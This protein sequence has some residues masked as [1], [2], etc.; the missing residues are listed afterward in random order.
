MLVLGLYFIFEGE[1]I[2]RYV[3]SRKDFYQYSQALNEFPTI[4]TALLSPPANQSIGKDFNMSLMYTILTDG[5]ND[6]QNPS[7]PSI[8]QV[9]FNYWLAGD[10]IKS[11]IRP[12]TSYTSGGWVQVEYT[13]ANA[14]QWSKTKVVIDLGTG[15]NS[16]CYGYN[17]GEVSNAVAK[18]GELHVLRVQPEKFIYLSDR[19]PCRKN[20]FLDELLTHLWEDA[21]KNPGKQ[22]K[23]QIM[24]Q[25]CPDLNTSERFNELP[26][27]ENKAGLKYMADLFLSV[28]RKPCT[29]LSYESKNKGPYPAPAPNQAMF[30]IF[31]AIPYDS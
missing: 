2:Q 10:A 16:N 6:I 20:P 14:S 26:V 30:S 9:D 13:F 17:D 18:V 19:T 1:V 24:H 4:E 22:C 23:A 7:S 3:A 25:I 11:K 28:N 29:K 21:S 8:L 12:L 5:K 27:C 15:N 31:L